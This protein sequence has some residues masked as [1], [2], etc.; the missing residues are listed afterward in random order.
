METTQPNR[1]LTNIAVDLQRL[2][3]HAD[4]L[5]PTLPAEAAHTLTKELGAIRALI[6]EATARLRILQETYPEQLDDA[7]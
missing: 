7:L 2:A 1:T 3:A 6:D 5:V 4:R